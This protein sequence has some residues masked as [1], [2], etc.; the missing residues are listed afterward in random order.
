[1]HQQKLQKKVQLQLAVLAVQLLEDVR[2]GRWG[3]A[4][5]SGK[6]L[7]VQLF[8]LHRAVHVELRRHGPGFPAIS[9]N[10]NDSDSK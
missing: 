5:S 3:W 1:M 4:I 2:N 9:I 8:G 6:D 10:I 7:D